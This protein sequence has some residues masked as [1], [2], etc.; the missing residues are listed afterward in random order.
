MGFP[1]EIHIGPLTYRVEMVEGL[2]ADD[3][4]RCHGLINH[5]ELLIKI[6]KSSPP[7]KQYLTLWHE[8]LHAIADQ[9]GISQEDFG[10]SIDTP[11]SLAIMGVLKQNPGL[12][13]AQAWLVF[14]EVENE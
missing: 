12:G 1:S 6:D 2:R 13:N 4:V 14:E 8:I 3:D 9:I 5:N 11:L 10:E 7:Q